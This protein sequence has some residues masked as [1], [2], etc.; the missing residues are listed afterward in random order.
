M[1]YDAGLFSLIPDF[2]DFAKTNNFQFKKSFDP[3]F[4]SLVDKPKPKS[5]LYDDT[6]VIQIFSKSV[7]KKV[8]EGSGETITK[9]QKTLPSV[10]KLFKNKDW[11]RKLDN[12]WILNKENDKLEIKGFNWFVQH[13]LYA[14][15][16]S[17]LPDIYNKFTKDNEE[18]SSVELA[19]KYYDKL[20]ST[21][22]SKILS[23]EEYKKELPKFL[24]EALMAK[25]TTSKDGSQIFNQ[26]YNEILLLTETLKL[27]FINQEKEEV[28]MK[29]LN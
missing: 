17:N 4:E 28:F 7:H 5:Q 19:K 6:M 12:S 21:Y 15:R 10:I 13:Y 20:V 24:S 14:S 8:G 9:E 1:V 26:D 11:R 16:F 27:I 2:K 3:K 18:T 25:F 22:K 29:Q 23:E